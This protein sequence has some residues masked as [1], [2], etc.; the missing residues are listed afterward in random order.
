MAGPTAPDNTTQDD[1]QQPPTSIGSE[2]FLQRMQSSIRTNPSLGLGAAFYAPASDGPATIRQG[3]PTTGGTT[4]F[5][6]KTT[7]TE[8][9]TST[10]GFTQPPPSIKGDPGVV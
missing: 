4:Q 1:Q 2:T 5:V 10:A 3:D 8:E 6:P 7:F 9:Y